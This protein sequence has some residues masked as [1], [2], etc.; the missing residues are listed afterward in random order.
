MDFDDGVFK[1]EVTSGD[2]TEG[3][4][5]MTESTFVAVFDDALHDEAVDALIA[6]GVAPEDA[7]GHDVLLHAAAALQ[8]RHA[9]HSDFVLDDACARENCP[10]VDLALGR[11]AHAD[12]DDT[13][14]ADVDVVADMNLVHQRVIAAY[15]GRSLFG[16]GA[17]NDDILTDDVVVANLNAASGAGFEMEVL[18]NGADDGILVDGVAATHLRA[19]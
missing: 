1:A 14:A 7:I 4:G 12:T 6:G 19:V 18:R 10:V 13:V 15:D 2:E 11:N 3:I 9:A 5:H 8:E 17:S 16:Q